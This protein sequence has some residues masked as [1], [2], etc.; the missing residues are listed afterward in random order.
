M[1][2]Q[3]L[4]A[5]IETLP[6]ALGTCSGCQE[7]TSVKVMLVKTQYHRNEAFPINPMW[8][9]YCD[10]CMDQLVSGNADVVRA[11]A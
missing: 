9:L 10:S 1:R 2:I 6:T 4:I 7:L 3:E 5:T 8:S 11:D